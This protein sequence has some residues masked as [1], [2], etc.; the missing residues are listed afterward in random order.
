MDWL[1]TQ[2]TLLR[3]AGWGTFS[4]GVEERQFAQIERRKKELLDS[5]A[6]RA[7]AGPAS[8]P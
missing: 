7:A 5:R 6:R 8:T 4:M 3:S 1:R 2:V